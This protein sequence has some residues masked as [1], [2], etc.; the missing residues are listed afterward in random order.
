MYSI[1]LLNHKEIKL[2]DLEKYFVDGDF[3]DKIVEFFSHYLI[4]NI[5]KGNVSY[6][7]EYYGVDNFIRYEN[8]NEDIGEDISKDI[9]IEIEKGVKE[10]LE[11][12]VND[13]EPQRDATVDEDFREIQ[14]FISSPNNIIL[15]DSKEK[16]DSLKYI[17]T[18]KLVF[19]KVFDNIFKQILSTNPSGDFIT[20]NFNINYALSNIV[21]KMNNL[22][23]NGRQI[24]STEW[25]HNLRMFTF[26]LID[27]IPLSYDIVFSGGSLYD[28][29]TNNVNAINDFTDLDIFV[30]NIDKV[31]RDI[32]IKIILTNLTA[33]GKVC[34]AFNMGAI[35]YIFVENIPRM[36]QVIFTNFNTPGDIINNFDASHVKMYYTGQEIYVN[37]QCIKGLLDNV[38]Y[39]S[40][41][42][43]L[44]I[45][46]IL[47]RGLDIKPYNRFNYNKNVFIDSA[48]E[49]NYELHKNKSEKFSLDESIDYSNST[50]RQSLMDILLNSMQVQNYETKKKFYEVNDVNMLC[51]LYNLPIDN[52]VTFTRFINEKIFTCYMEIK[53]K[54][55]TC[56]KYDRIIL[57]P[58]GTS[59]KKLKR[60]IIFPQNI[61]ICGRVA[62]NFNYDEY[63]VN[64]YYEHRNVIILLISIEDNVDNKKMLQN[65]KAHCEMLTELSINESLA[66]SGKK[67]IKSKSKIAR[68]FKLDSP[69]YRDGEFDIRVSVP[70]FLV[71]KKIKTNPFSV[72]KYV[73]FYCDIMRCIN[74]WNNSIFYNLIARD[75]KSKIIEDN[76]FID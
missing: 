3:L 39:Y 28:I 62:H 36:I 69:Y 57:P 14:S 34:Y 44:R 33:A 38:S 12:L 46:K 23:K 9:D 24:I 68:N 45:Y 54:I 5:L 50:M 60:C 17:N 73:H 6:S 29:V 21:L 8:I 30:T 40:G 72:G 18:V 48:F 31:N 53:M 19:N 42:K 56:D 76:T 32:L 1:K 25:E 11:D 10:Y 51:K 16:V 37:P 20:G 26:G 55:V 22:L 43:L 47:A 59:Y 70:K 66:N 75:S 13:I 2:D 64:K 74:S 65:F 7:H 71:S 35:H 58:L 41:N 52:L 27:Y 15:V 63:E 4:Q 61:E 49:K 67:K